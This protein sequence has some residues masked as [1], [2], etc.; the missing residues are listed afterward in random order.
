MLAED[1]EHP[2]VVAPAEVGVTVD[3]RIIEPAVR[4]DKNRNKTFLGVWWSN[5]TN[6]LADPDGMMWRILGP[7]G[8][9][10][11]WR[12]PEFDRLGA[13]AHSSLDPD[14][15]QRNYRRMFELFREH[16]PWLP[17]LQPYESYGVANHVE[18]YP[19]GNHYFN[20]RAENLRLVTE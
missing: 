9:H 17:I 3:L 14:L 11:Y 18:W 4:A 19:Y 12:H 16:L 15:R 8:I 6:T 13:E 20:L 5:P 7:G 1:L 2:P 10:D